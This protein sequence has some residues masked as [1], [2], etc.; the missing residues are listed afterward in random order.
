MKYPFTFSFKTQIQTILERGLSITDLGTFKILM[1]ST[2]NSHSINEAMF[3]KTIRPCVA[4][5]MHFWKRFLFNTTFHGPSSSQ[6]LSLT[7]SSCVVVLPMLSDQFLEIGQSHSKIQQCRKPINVEGA[8]YVTFSNEAKLAE[9]YNNDK[10]KCTNSQ[11][12]HHQQSLLYL[13]MNDWTT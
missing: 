7:V 9:D 2:S 8:M 12:K 11:N 6:Q 13:F 10:I 4:L 5:R 1:N 3:P